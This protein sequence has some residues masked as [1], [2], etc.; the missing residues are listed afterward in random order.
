MCSLQIHSFLSLALYGGKCSASRHHRS[1]AGEKPPPP[2][3]AV[4]EAE[5]TPETVWTICRK[6]KS[7]APVGIR[8]PYHPTRRIKRKEF[9]DYLTDSWSHTY[10]KM[11][12]FYVI[13]L[14]SINYRYCRQHH[15][16]RRHRHCHRHHNHHHHHHHHCYC[17]CLLL[18]P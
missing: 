13:A 4:Q 11:T 9:A 18:T 16:R 14:Y 15:R 8:T 3:P 17:C 6:E 12:K 1:T 2:V 5:W 7:C 10:T